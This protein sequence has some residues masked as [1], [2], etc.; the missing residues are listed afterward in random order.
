MKKLT[1]IFTLLI[2]GLTTQ[3]ASAQT[4]NEKNTALLI[5]ITKFLEEN[6][7]DAKAKDYRENAF[8]Y[9]VETKDV[10]VTLCSDVAKEALK[11]KNKFSGEL[12]LQQSF[13]MA[14]F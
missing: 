10:S 9:L 14:V 7:F 4:D 11:K 6:P 3:I 2:I 13:G 5:K 1:I 12:L 8:R